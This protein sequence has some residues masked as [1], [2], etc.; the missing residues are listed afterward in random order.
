MEHR[1]QMKLKVLHCNF[2]YIG[3]QSVVQ[4]EAMVYNDHAENPEQQ[5][6]IHCSPGHITVDS[7]EYKYICISIDS[8][9]F[10]KY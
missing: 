8:P 9:G 4:V 3:S 10:D 2:V 6:E 5:D 1:F 7:G